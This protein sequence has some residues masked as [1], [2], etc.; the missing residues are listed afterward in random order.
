MKGKRMLALLTAICLAAG[1]AGCGAAPVQS[2][3]PAEATAAQEVLAE[4]PI[5]TE[6]AS[7]EDVWL[8]YDSNGVPIYTDRD[9]SG[10][11]G[12]VASSSWYATK[13]GL[14]ILEAGGNAAD[15]A[16]AVAYALGVVEPYTSGIGG[17][18]FMTLYNAETGEVTM[19]DFREIAPAAATAEMWLEEDGSIGYYTDENG[20][21]LS[22]VY[23]RLN[24]LGGMAVAVPG[25]VAGL[26]YVL[27]HYASGSFTR[28][29]LMQSAIDYAYEGWLVTPTMKSSTLDEYTEICTMETLSSYYLDEIGLPLETN[30]TVTN[31]DLAHTLELIAEGGAEAFYQGPVAEAIAA[32][33]QKYGGVMTT[34][35]LANY[36]VE[37]RE[38][39]ISTYR[40]YTIYA[41]APS[42][43]GGTHLIEI[44]NILENYDMAALEVNSSEYIHLFAE[45]MKLAFADKEEYMADTA[46]TEVPLQTLISKEYAAARAAEMAEG[47][48][49]YEAGDAVQEHGSTTSFSVVDKDGNMVTCT[50]TIGDFYGSKVAVPGYGFILNDEMYDFDTDPDSVNCAAGGK[51]PLSSMAPTVVLDPEGQPWLT[52]G[53]PGG[54]RIF[55]VIA[56]VIERMIDYS[57]D[58]QEAIETVRVF[59]SDSDA[60]Y[61][62][63]G[64]VNG[65]SEETLA[66]LTAIGYTLS[67]KNTYDLYFGGV[68]GVELRSDGTLHA[69]ADPRRGGKAL[70]L[71]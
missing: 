49:S 47:N 6:E 21:T 40:D 42:S 23:A 53:T 19:L 28:Q 52:I 64:G 58:I 13:A 12:A 25:E 27:E 22:S 46:F 14:E 60:L 15:A 8:P 36:S 16:I 18:G 41:L 30:A 55:S 4:V 24:R 71:E 57:M 10:K 33:V 7:A 3:E 51:R 44:L 26:E 31:E 66:E 34:E 65:I 56:Q 45:A 63:E 1:T 20:T 29:E 32:E 9:A 17:G 69:G 39:L 11:G 59:S 38:P 68:Q 62:E 48:G 50:Q 37:L 67:P 70:A 35:D 2:T 54:T 5:I 43:S 61:Y